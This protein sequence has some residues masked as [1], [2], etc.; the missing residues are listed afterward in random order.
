MPTEI[1]PNALAAMLQ[2]G[3]PV[4][5]VDVRQPWEHAHAALPGSRLVPLHELAA[6]WEEIRPPAGA[7]VVIYCHHGVRSWQAA[8]WLESRGL[9]P[10]HSLAGGIDAWSVLVD[11]T[12]PRY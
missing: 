9:T 2:A 10:V 4:Y 3:D 11:P 7:A 1:H 6:R 5:L 8:A 12:T